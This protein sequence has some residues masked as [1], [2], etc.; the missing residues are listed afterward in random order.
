MDN[1]FKD[2]SGSATALAILANGGGGGGSTPIQGNVPPESDTKGKLGQIY[3]YNHAGRHDVYVCVDVDKSG[4]TPVYTWA[5]LTDQATLSGTTPPTP[6][7]AAEAGQFYICNIDG[8]YDV[9]L[10]VDA[11]TESV[12]AVYTWARLT[13]YTIP[14]ITITTSGAVT[15][16]LAPASIYH[17]TGDLTSLTITLAPPTAVGTL[18]QYHLDF[19]TGA[20]APTFTA[21][22]VHFDDLEMEPNTRYEIDILNNWGAV[23]SWEITNS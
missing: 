21:T 19:Q 14:E 8:R 7:T 15:Q 11:D 2:F 23:L 16:E 10:C 5:R 3:I 22:G 13:D 18:A 20:T 1:I 6:Q 9:Y 17:F 4:A 12:P